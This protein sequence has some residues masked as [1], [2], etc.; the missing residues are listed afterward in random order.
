MRAAVMLVDFVELRYGLDF[1]PAAKWLGAVRDAPLTED[2]R[3]RID[4]AN[5]EKVLRLAE[6]SRRQQ[7]DR[8]ERLR[9]REIVHQDN[10]LINQISRD[11]NND[12]ENESLWSCLELAHEARELD[13]FDYMT[14][15]GF[16]VQE[17]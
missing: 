7:A 13:E 16:E 3:T 8:Q 14:A 6:E 5:K 11:L 17:S 2:E 15:C 4:Q 10:R 12:V 1:W 9:L